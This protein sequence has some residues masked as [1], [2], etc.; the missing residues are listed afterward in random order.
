MRDFILTSLI[1]VFSC[2]FCIWLLRPIAIKIGFVDRP[3]ERKQHEQNVPMIGGVVI[4]FGF[5]FALL[6]V[7]VS[8]M[9]YRSLLGGS[10][11][12][13]LMGVADDFHDLS[14]KLRLFGQLMV[15]LVVVCWGGLYVNELGNLFF[16]GNLTLGLWAIPVTVLLVMVYINAFNMIDGQDGL[17]GC[18]ALT[19][20]VWLLLFAYQLHL[21]A[22]EHFLV[23]I[24]LLVLVFLS[25]NMTVPWRSSASIF[26]GDSGSTLLAF[27][28]GWI[29]L[30]I[31]K[32]NL[33][34]VH[35][36][37]ILWVIALPLFD[38]INVS[39]HRTLQGKSIFTAGRDHFH[40][41]LNFYGVNK[42][43]ST[44]LIASLSAGFGAIGFILNAMHVA[45]GI[46]FIG[47][48]V[49][50]VLYLVMIEFARL[51]VRRSHA[52]SAEIE[53]PHAQSL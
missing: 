44:L 47:F 18:V 21:V 49:V 17:A 37:A 30:S 10:L 14:V 24:T 40:H 9:P 11:L 45:D 48:L 23:I 20:A 26:L 33:H 7:H 12:L 51:P 31:S 19:Q 29:A 2:L 43:L 4:F 5:C 28:L 50:L 22:F 15:A 27:L 35:P 6:H 32:A 13:L 16:T 46:S 39:L 25:F 1:A 41:M 8:L 52:M 42:S 36:V 38:M 34:L 3:N 53:D